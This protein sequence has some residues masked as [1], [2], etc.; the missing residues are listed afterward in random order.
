MS[1]RENSY[2][3]EKSINKNQNALLQ[4]VK[5]HHVGNVTGIVQSYI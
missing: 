1:V 4:N 2:V 5:K 3:Q